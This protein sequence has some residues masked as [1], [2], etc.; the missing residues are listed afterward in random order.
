MGDGLDADDLVADAVAA[1]GIEDVGDDWF[2]TPLQAWSNDLRQANLTDLGRRFFRSQ[3]VKDVA[4]RLR[5]LDT[6]RAHPEIF[7]VELP[8]IVHITGMERSGTTLLHNLVAL[9]AGARPI[10]RWE[11]MEPVPPPEAATAATDPRIARV[12]AAI[13]PLRGSLLEQMHWVDA[14]DPE[15]C[16]WG[17]VDCVSFLGQAAGSVMPAW[18]AFVSR[19]DQTRSF[20]HYRQLLQLLTWKHPVPDGG[21]LAL[22]AP[23]I[24]VHIAEFAAVFPEA[25]F[26]VPDRDPF[27]CL[28][29]TA[30]MVRS[31]VDPFCVDNPVRGP[32]D[33]GFER[34]LAD[35]DFDLVGAFARKLDAVAAFED[36][37]PER[38]VHVPYP[39][40][41]GDPARVVTGLVDALGLSTD[42]RLAERIDDFLAAQRAG[43]RAAPPAQLDTLGF[44]H[45][46]V[47]AQPSIASY[48]ARYAIAPERSRLT[49]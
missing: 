47:L 29:S 39:V 21:F 27:R 20:E 11:L 3:A 1:T 24:A 23:Q 17:F 34:G 6:L 40:L 15:E 31:I 33:A 46:D 30:F 42:P 48:C 26:V 14:D 35:G 22:K 18:G 4:R 45:D 16:V 2:L 5:V 12:Q 38:I 37:H 19:A 7:E 9:H 49:G 43:R 41:V 25:T 28:A 32:A 36:A 13:E 8:P 10:L 44:D